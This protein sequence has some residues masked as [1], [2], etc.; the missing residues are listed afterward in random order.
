MLA[1][2]TMTSQREGRAVSVMLT[3]VQ[4]L[5]HG[6]LIGLLVKGGLVMIPLFISSV[7]SLTVI[8]ERS[9][10]WW[11]VRKQAIDTTLLQCVAAGKLAHALQMAHASSHPVA[12]VLYAGLTYHHLAPGTAMTVAAQ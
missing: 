5:L 2:G 3:S 4:A 10:F 12:R 7:I 9:V 1:V 8:L 11:R 6:G